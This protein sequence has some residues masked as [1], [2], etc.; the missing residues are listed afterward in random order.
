MALSPGSLRRLRELLIKAVSASLACIA[1]ARVDSPI[2]GLQ[3][4]VRDQHALSV[5]HLVALGARHDRVI[6]CQMHLRVHVLVIAPHVLFHEH[7]LIVLWLT[8]SVSQT[9]LIE[10]NNSHACLNGLL[11][12]NQALLR[13][14]FLRVHRELGIVAASRGV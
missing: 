3:R 11:L 9:R 7:L 4:L 2:Q 8:C 6:T 10:A 1:N 14:G 12:I 5:D 13:Q